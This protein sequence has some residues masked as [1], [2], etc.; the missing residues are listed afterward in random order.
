MV[1]V[2]TPG[3]GGVAGGA[4]D[5]NGLEVLDV[6]TCVALLRSARIGR[7]A[8]TDRAMPV[9]LPVNFVVVSTG[10]V[11]ATGLGTKLAA[12]TSRS[13]VAFEA[14]DI[15]QVTSRGWSVCVTG[16]STRVVDRDVL[17]EVTAANLEPAVRSNMQ[18]YVH[19]AFDVVTGRYLR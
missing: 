9:I 10:L 5:R 6:P 12:A 8:I 4:R 3:A 18:V 16:R 17:D 14:D 7:V 11:F 2:T 15:E 13:V 1:L 19:I